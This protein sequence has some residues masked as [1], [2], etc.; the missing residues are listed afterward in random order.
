VPQWAHAEASLPTEG[1]RETVWYRIEFI[2]G[3]EREVKRVVE[4][5]KGRERERV[6]K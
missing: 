6:K 1:P 3:M 5:E 2:E 4:T